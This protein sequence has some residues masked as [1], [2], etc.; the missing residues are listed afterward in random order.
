MNAIILLDHIVGIILVAKELDY[1]FQRE[2]N[3]MYQQLINH[4]HTKL[5]YLGMHSTRTTRG[6]PRCERQNRFQNRSG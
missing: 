4:L 6:S 2:K 5:L 3:N 1:F